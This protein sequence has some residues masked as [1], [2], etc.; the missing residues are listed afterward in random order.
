M[1]YQTEQRQL[2]SSTLCV[3]SLA[4]IPPH[5]YTYV[6]TLARRSRRVEI[7]VKLIPTRRSGDNTLPF[8]LPGTA[9]KEPAR[10][11]RSS[12]NSL[13]DIPSSRSLLISN[14]KCPRGGAC[15]PDA[16]SLPLDAT[17]PRVDVEAR[18]FRGPRRLKVNGQARTCVPLH[19]GYRGM[20]PPPPRFSRRFVSFDSFGRLEQQLDTS[21]PLL[22][23]WA[24]IEAVVTLS[25]RGRRT[26]LI[27]ENGEKYERNRGRIAERARE[28]W[29]IP[30]GKQRPT[31]R[32][33]AAAFAFQSDSAF[34]GCETTTTDHRVLRVVNGPLSPGGESP[35]ASRNSKVTTRP[36]REQWGISVLRKEEPCGGGKKRIEVK[37]TIEILKKFSLPLSDKLSSRPP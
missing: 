23:D 4:T 2:S 32:Q 33:P 18:A 27:L 12:S 10:S 34:T 26:D 29:R 17:G 20:S 6:Y 37:G 30:L 24:S 19:C 13:H 14:Q 21:Y 7:R 8:N 22:N 1:E 11:A 36:F 16:N 35:R 15:V 9:S 28:K 25:F 3:K 31:E 5:V